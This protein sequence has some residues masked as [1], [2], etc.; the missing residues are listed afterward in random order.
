MEVNRKAI[1]N[2]GWSPLNHKLVEHPSLHSKKTAVDAY[3][4]NAPNLSDM[5]IEKADGMA[6]SILNKIVRERMQSN[7][8]ADAAKKRLEDGNSIFQ[9]IK[10]AKQV[11]AGI[12]AKNGVFAL[13]N[14]EFLAG[15][16]A[17]Q[18]KEKA[19][20][21]KKACKKCKVILGNANRVKDTQ[22]RHGH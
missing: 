17:S 20:K 2:Q 8:A 5:N 15:L 4:H 11:L 10:D 7:A 21:T 13:D 16:R 14:T 1:A 19:V 18:E 6:E 9:S 3:S 12:L 22:E